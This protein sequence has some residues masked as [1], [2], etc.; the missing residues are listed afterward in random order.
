MAVLVDLSHAVVDGMVT[1][2]GLPAPVV[3]EVLGREQ[4]RARYARGTEFHIGTIQLCGNT[5]TYVD[6]PFHR[7]AD[8][9]DLAALPL[10]RLA[11]LDAVTVDATEP[12]G[13][14]VD[15]ALLLGYELAGRAVLVRTGWSRHFGTEQY[16][17]GHPFLT[18]EAAQHLVDEGAAL[19]GIDSLNVDDTATG[20][21]PV[22]SLLLAAGIPLCEHLTALDRL[23][24][25]GYRFSAVPVKVV[26]MG[27]FP[28][29]AYARLP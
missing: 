26:G 10:E 27:S 13:R 21:R 9:A 12:R 3:G 19:L 1:Y 4:S 24:R 8:G 28:V 14:A 22:H 29:R 17:T 5:G 20:E 2:P 16:G 15:R 11:D 18:A 23:P 6:A 25:D 7:C